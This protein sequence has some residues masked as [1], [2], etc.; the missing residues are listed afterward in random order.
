METNRNIILEHY[1]NNKKY[2][3]HLKKLY[4]SAFPREERAPFFVI[5]SKVKKEKA[6]M[7][8]AKD[9]ETFIGLV[10]TVCYKDLVYIFYFAINEGLRGKGYGGKV[11]TALKEKYN[12]KRIFL[13][14]EQLDK[15]APNYNQ[16]LKRHSFYLHNGFEDLGCKIKEAGVI[17]DVMGIG[18]HVLPEEYNALITNWAGNLIR[19]FVDM[20]IIEEKWGYGY[21]KIQFCT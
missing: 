7:L 15:S 8:I 9:E 14:R 12:G 11:L 5:M 19:K 1:H 13:A 16:R 2:N 18:G 21:Y 10:Y 3:K 17:Y 4:K 20:R 6:D